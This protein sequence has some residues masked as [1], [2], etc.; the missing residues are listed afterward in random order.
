MLKQIRKPQMKLFLSHPQDLVK[1]DHPYRKLLSI[2]N[3]SELTKPLESL[4]NKEVGR[5][6]FHI[7]SGFAALVLQ[8]MEDL[9]DRELERFLT[10]NIAAKF[11]CGFDMIEKTPDHTYFCELRKKIGT[12]RLGEMFTLVNDKLRSKGLVSNIFTFVDASTMISK[13][14][15]WDERDKAIKAGEEKLNNKNIDKFARD[16]DASYGCKGENKHWYGYKRNVAVCM[17]HGFITKVAATTAK[18]TDAKA[19]K[20]S[21]LKEA[22]LWQTKVIVQK[23]QLKLWL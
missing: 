11:F 13:I 18:V 8:W 22:W 14:A 23:M 4:Y 7:E 5:P 9:S 10:E 12:S 17:K 3:F 1:K 16:K 6:G 15:L 20:L 2:I 19:L 21:A